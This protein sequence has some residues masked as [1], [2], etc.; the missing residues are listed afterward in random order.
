MADYKEYHKQFHEAYKNEHWDLVTRAKTDATVKAEWKRRK[1]EFAEEYH[2]PRYPFMADIFDFAEEDRAEPNSR[3]PFSAE[4]KVDKNVVYKTV[5]G[6]ELVMD[7]Y[8]PVNQKSKAPCV[9]DIPGGGW[10]IH[11]RP[12]R[13]GYARMFAAMG[14]VVAVIDHR[15]CPAVFFPEN[16]HDCVDAYNFLVDNAE[17]Y[18]IDPDNITVTGDSSGGH[19]TACV[20]CVGTSEGYA[21]KLGIPKT[22]TKPANLIFISGAFSFEVM[23]RIPCTH[24]FIVRYVTGTKSR[25]EFRNWKFY[26]ESIPYNY[27]TEK[28]PESYNNGGMTD[29]LCLGEAKRMAGILTKAG[30]KN[31][32]KVGKNLLDSDHCYVLRSPFKASRND[33]LLLMTWY[34]E[35]QKEKGNDLTEGYDRVKEFLTNYD[36]VI[37]GK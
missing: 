26:K 13:D 5:D 8:Y 27:I 1:K 33:M 11:N 14:A 24:S 9:M 18:D 4:I 16:L 36:R 21:E 3:T 31:E 15:L 2:M 23:Y 29:V 7:I 19:L 10:M 12:R 35:R 22:K 28:Y 17:K 6:E 34:Y 32:Y 30:V 37:K 25:K 20:G